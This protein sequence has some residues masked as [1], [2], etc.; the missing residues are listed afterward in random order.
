MSERSHKHGRRL[1]RGAQRCLGRHA[2]VTRHGFRKLRS[3]H[4]RWLHAE[5]RPP[6]SFAAC[7][8][9]A[10]IRAWIR[11]QQDR[12]NAQ[13]YT[14][15]RQRWWWWWWCRPLPTTAFRKKINLS[16]AR[17]DN[18]HTA[19]FA[20][21]RHPVAFLRTENST[22]ASRSALT[23]APPLPMRPRG[24]GRRCRRRGACAARRA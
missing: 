18:K 20:H 12:R 4:A 15:F 6:P 2:L 9:R 17:A 3:L 21:S 7:S 11:A 5:P 23:W 19:L 10:W 16:L 14:R 1:E 8:A 22:R 24:S 13:L